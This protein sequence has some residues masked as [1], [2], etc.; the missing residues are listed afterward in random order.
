MAFQNIPDEKLHEMG[1]AAMRA[2]PNIADH[3]RLRHDEAALLLGVPIPTYRHW[4][5]VP[6][7]AQLDVNHLERLSLILSI[8]KALQTLLPRADAAD[9]WLR[10]P[11]YN[12]LFGGRPPLDRL[13][14]GQ[15]SGLRAVRRH[16]DAAAEG[17]PI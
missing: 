17:S 15:T 9:S 7:D 16:L 12:S 10:R 11:N 1:A 5:N 2:Y 14:S 13:L 8:Y 3:W 6:E 4:C